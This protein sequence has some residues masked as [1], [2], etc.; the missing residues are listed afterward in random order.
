M[1]TYIVTLALVIIFAG[2]SQN[3]DFVHPDGELSD[4]LVVHTR[5]ARNFYILAVLVLVVVGGFRYGVGTDYFSYYGKIANYADFI[6]ALKN[7]DEPGIK[8]FYATIQRFTTNEIVPIVFFQLF[9][10]GLSL[11][12]IYRNTDQLFLA[13]V[14]FLF[15]GCWHS[16]FNAVRQCLAATVVFCG[17]PYL[18]ERKL[19]KYVLVVFVAF[20]FHKSA[21]IM[22]VPYFV[23]H[24]KIN[25]KNVL[26]MILGVIVVLL[27]Y[28]RLIAFTGF[29][30]G[31]DLSETGEYGVRAVNIFR[32]LVAVTPSI[33]YLVLYR[34][35]PIDQN[36]AFFIN[37]TIMH[38]V[39][40]VLGSRSAYIARVGIYTSPFMA[41]AIPE[42]NKGIEDPNT[43]RMLN[44]ILIILYG[45]Y[46]LYEISN[47][48]SLNP[49][50]W[51]NPSMGVGL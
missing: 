32:I 7:F 41:L 34:N 49:Y 8:L 33:F 39:V 20:L 3:C 16:A 24:N 45:I 42:L 10:V 12:I 14:L 2:I 11:R 18:R 30:M 13:L 5:S 29:I 23:I 46:F 35:K 26:F 50:K 9:T 36:A 17:L 28:D 31:G 47:S 19:W 4:G 37:L 22:I 21:I 40:M 25:L 44:L 51:W 43:R 1:A 27:S 15:L 38:A 6:E 48:G